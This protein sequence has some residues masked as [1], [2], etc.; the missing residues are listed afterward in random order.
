MSQ[1]SDVPDPRTGLRQRRVGGTIHSGPGSRVRI[2]QNREE[3]E[4]IAEGIW[5][6]VDELRNE[7][8]RMGT[9]TSRARM[10]PEVRLGV[11]PG[12]NN[13]E[14]DSHYSPFEEKQKAPL[15]Y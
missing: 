10:G 14:V 4:N 15:W 7:S 3:L 6:R 13:G 12:R 2:S 5:S 9:G 11:G 1:P 8:E